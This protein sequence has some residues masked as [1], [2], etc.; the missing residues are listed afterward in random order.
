MSRSE[1]EI[2]RVLA[3]VKETQQ[4]VTAYVPSGRFQSLLRLV[5]DRAGRILLEFS[6]SEVANTELLQ[7]A[8]C[9]F[10]CE[11][12]GWHIEFVCA[13]PRAVVYA[14]NALIQCRFPEVLVTHR[15]EHERAKLD[16]HLLLRVVAD[17]DGITPFD[18]R[19]VD[20]GMGGI[21]FMIYSTAI[22]LEPGT[23]LEG[24]RIKLPNGRI[25]KADLEVRYSIPVTFSNG[26]RAM[27][28]GCRFVNL[29][30]DVLSLAKRYAKRR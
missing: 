24:C 21:G 28:S 1:D 10:H 11:I 4:L 7:R 6:P 13:E 20:I 16:P 15:R 18:A 23:V 14:G 5:D 29:T 17:A 27:R 8:R 9:S 12:A 22:T 2:A 3:S 30:R 19:I 26:R 25:C